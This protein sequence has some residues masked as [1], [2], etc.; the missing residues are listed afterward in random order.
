MSGFGLVCSFFPISFFLCSFLTSF[1]FALS[2]EMTALVIGVNSCT[3]SV[4]FSLHI[5]SSVHKPQT[6]AIVITFINWTCNKW[7]KWFPLTAVCHWKA[8]SRVAGWVLGANG[9]TSSV[10]VVSFPIIFN[11][12]NF[13][14]L[15]YYYLY[16]FFCHS[17]LRQKGI[18]TLVLTSLLWLNQLPW[19]CNKETWSRDRTKLMTSQWCTGMNPFTGTI[20]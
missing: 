19:C 10:E 3:H 1:L 13:F 6:T 4:L 9:R 14:Y 20:V 17:N 11:M 16:V 2:P 12:L 15:L 7:T 18:V 5:L 8:R